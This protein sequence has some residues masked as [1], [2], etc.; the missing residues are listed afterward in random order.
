MKAL[1]NRNSNRNDGACHCWHLEQMRLAIDDRNDV[2]PNPLRRSESGDLRLE[3]SNQYIIPI[4]FCPFC[5]GSLPE[6]QDE[7][8]DP[9]YRPTAQMYANRAIDLTQE[10]AKSTLGG[11]ATGGIVINHEQDRIRL[12]YKTDIQRDYPA[13]VYE[14]DPIAKVVLS[15]TPI[16]NKDEP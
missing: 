16:H 4:Y 11:L 7:G 2:R 5:G 1:F 6:S 9:I 14:V 13:V 3:L 15:R 8:A 12:T 10:D